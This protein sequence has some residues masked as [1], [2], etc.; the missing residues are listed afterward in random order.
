MMLT[1]GFIGFY[2]ITGTKTDYPVLPVHL[3]I[4]F[5]V[6]GIKPEFNLLSGSSGQS[7]DKL[8]C[9]VFSVSVDRIRGRNYSS[10]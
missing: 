6:T 5:V 8:K 1:F 4:I 9:Y 10:A 7:G 2:Y 3:V